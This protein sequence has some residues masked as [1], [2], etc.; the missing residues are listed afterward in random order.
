[1]DKPIEFIRSTDLMFDIENYI[2]EN[3]ETIQKNPIQAINELFTELQTLNNAYIDTQSQYK[4][5]F[6]N[7]GVYIDKNIPNINDVKDALVN[8]SIASYIQLEFVTMVSE[9]IVITE[10]QLISSDKQNN[11]TILEIEEIEE[12]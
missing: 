11:L 8:K 7:I 10:Y 4:E 3:L 2:S 12:E 9:P 6:E 5:V 1:M